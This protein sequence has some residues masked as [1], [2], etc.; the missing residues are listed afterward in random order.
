MTT[1]VRE[2]ILQLLAKLSEYCPE[3]RF[4]QLIA[5]LSYLAK[6]PSNEAIWDVEDEE[7]LA[8]ARKLLKE[9]RKRASARPNERMQPT[10]NLPV[11][12]VSEIDVGC[13]A[14]SG[15]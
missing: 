13:R 7:L 1:Q 5:N 14:P 12:V 10:G 4:G 15:G 9:R 8:A 3:V 6:G 2:D 11:S